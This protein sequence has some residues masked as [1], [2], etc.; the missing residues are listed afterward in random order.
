MCRFNVERVKRGRERG[1]FGFHWERLLSPHSVF[2][3]LS[4]FSSLSKAKSGLCVAVSLLLCS[5]LC[6]GTH[7]L[8]TPVDFKCS[9]FSAHVKTLLSIIVNDLVSGCSGD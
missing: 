5:S 3:L 9:F 8:C 2:V 1:A 4:P 6:C 7:S